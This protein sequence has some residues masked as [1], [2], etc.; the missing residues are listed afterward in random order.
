VT[1]IAE[2]ETYFLSHTGHDK[3]LVREVATRIHFAG[4]STFFDEWSIHLGESI[5]G[6]ISEAIKHYEVLVLFWSKAAE[7]SL[8]VGREFSAAM[9]KFIQDPSRGIVV[10]KLDETEVPSIIGD[11]KYLDARTHPDPNYIA[12]Q[13]M[14]F[15][16]NDRLIA[17]QRTLEDMDLGFEFF[18]GYGV[19]VACPI[20]A[21]PAKNLRGFS[22]TDE[23]RDDLYGG[24]RCPECGW[25]D[26]GEVI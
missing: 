1:V 6:A 14:G 22:E 3:D 23:E 19:A 8:W 12:D 11:L 25:N 2:A 26:G 13:I 18:P 9:T 5:P 7:A 17:M 10:V 16:G 15:R 24:V 4:R 20:C 21:N